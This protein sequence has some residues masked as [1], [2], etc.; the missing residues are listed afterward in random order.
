MNSFY[1]VILHFLGRECFLVAGHTDKQLEQLLFIVANLG[2]S[3][4]SLPLY[5]RFTFMIYLLL[6]EA[7]LDNNITHSL[8]ERVVF[9]WLSWRTSDSKYRYYKINLF[10]N[11]KYKLCVAN[12]LNQFIKNIYVCT[13]IIKHLFTHTYPAFKTFGRS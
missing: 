7:G 4:T 13:K 10:Q 8:R 6:P 3:K 5:N 9:E 12:L 11:N 2:L 1:N